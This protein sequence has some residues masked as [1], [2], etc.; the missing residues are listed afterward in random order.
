MQFGPPMVKK[1]MLSIVEGTGWNEFIELNRMAFSDKLPRNSESRA[2]SVAMRLI[3]K[4]YPHIKWVLSFSDATQCGDGT[5]YRASGFV[6][7]QIKKNTSLIKLTD[8]TI[9]CGMTYNKGKHI[10]ASGGKA[11]NPVGSTPLVGYQLR[12][13]YFIDKSCREKL[14]CPEIPFSE[15]KKRGIGMY[16][17]KLIK[18]SGDA[19]NDQL[20]EGGL[21][22][23]NEL[24]PNSED[25]NG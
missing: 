24:H 11:S 25:L 20:T 3:K 7:T 10:L 21:I 12:Y 16:K 6:L 5:I 1:H 15:I 8:G 2:I 18:H 23:T 13:I 17:G 22:P 9:A 19:V 4:H 14:T